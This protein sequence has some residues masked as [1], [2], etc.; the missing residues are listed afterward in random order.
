MTREAG[1][2]NVQRTANGCKLATRIPR[3]DAGYRPPQ[4]V[5]AIDFGTTNCSLAYIIAGG[6]ES[7]APKK[8]NMLCFD[9][10]FYRVPTAV[11]FNK[12]GA[13]TDFGINAFEAYSNQDEDEQSE[14]AYFEQIK[15]DLQN[16][17]VV[18]TVLVHTP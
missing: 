18:Y 12:D 7:S 8:P 5:A 16:D 2:M 14:C 15:M 9:G 3:E 13:V 4:N 6:F 11:L 1:K 10:A 17:E